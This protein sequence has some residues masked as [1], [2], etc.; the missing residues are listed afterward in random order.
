MDNELINLFNTSYLYEVYKT[1]LDEP[2]DADL[3]TTYKNANEYP[4]YQKGY[5]ITNDK[6][7]LLNQTI[8]IKHL[9]HCLYFVYTD[10][11]KKEFDDKYWF[12]IGRL[13]NNLYFSYEMGCS[14][15]GFGLGETSIMYFSKTKE[16]LLL[17][18]L[19]N[20]HRNLI[21]S[22]LPYFETSRV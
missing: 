5:L 20:K 13:K 4:H 6:I 10:F 12:F 8:I 9:I 22:N 19:T 18:G 11:G 14:G 1:V 17:Y 3:R 15:T 21:N 2:L 16:L 7:Q